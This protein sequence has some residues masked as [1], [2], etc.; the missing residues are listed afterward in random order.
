MNS[1]IKSTLA[2]AS[3]PVVFPNGTSTLFIGHSLFVP[4]SREFDTFVE[5]KSSLFPNHK[6]EEFFQGGEKG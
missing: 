4:V 6:H 2:S 3:E 1:I 5:K